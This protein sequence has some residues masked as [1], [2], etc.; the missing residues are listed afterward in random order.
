MKKFILI[1]WAPT[2]GKSTLAQNLSKELDLP[3][4]STDQIRML[5]KIYAHREE[6]GWL[7]LPEWHDSVETFLGHYTVE[8]ITDMEFAQAHDVWP[9]I[10]TMIND[11]YTYANG[12]IIEWVNVTPEVVHKN[13]KNR[14][15]VFYIIII[16]DNIDRIRNVIYTR[17]LFADAKSYSDEYKEKEVQWVKLF[18][19]KLKSDCEKYD[20]PY[21]STEKKDSDIK[22]ILP[23]VDDFFE[24]RNK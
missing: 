1:W 16:D 17:G 3:W 8:E 24:N 19:E 20:I 9:G 18:T 10:Q 12:C 5:M 13:L 23:L 6:T 22:K 2:T 15:D 4:F 7:F 14:P 21:I 11:C